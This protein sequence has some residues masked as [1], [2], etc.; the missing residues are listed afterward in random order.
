MYRSSSDYPFAWGRH[1]LKLVQGNPL[2]DGIRPEA[3]L[4]ACV[5]HIIVDNL[6]PV[7]ASTVTTFMLSEA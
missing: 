7:F 5:H 3:A 6:K 1:L 2:L 4:T